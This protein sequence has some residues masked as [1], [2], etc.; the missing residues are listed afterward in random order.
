MANIFKD[1]S[2]PYLLVLMLT[3]AGWMFNSAVENASKLRIIE[4]HIEDGRDGAVATKTILLE[5]KSLTGSVNVGGFVLSCQTPA[6]ESSCLVKLPSVQKEAQYI[7][8]GNVVLATNPQ[9]ISDN[10]V[11]FPALLPPRGEAGYRIGISGATD[12]IRLVYNVDYDPV[13]QTQ[14]DLEILLIE[15]KPIDWNSWRDISNKLLAFVFENYIALLSL[16]IIVLIST[17]GL[18]I[19]LELL[20]LIFGRRKAPPANKSTLRLTIE[21]KTHNVEVEEL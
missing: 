18:W 21:G 2:A 10:S 12:A 3:G 9:M 11:V 16:G 15:D 8:A 14:P 6:A 4:Y 20:G 19:F 5:N 13:K 17:I 1:S 7:A